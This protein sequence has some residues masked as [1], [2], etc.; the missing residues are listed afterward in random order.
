MTAFDMVDREA[1]TWGLD[2]ISHRNNTSKQLTRQYQY[3]YNPIAGDGATV[4]II[5][6]GIYTEHLVSI[7]PQRLKVEDPE[8]S[9]YISAGI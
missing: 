6:S 9:T 1:V 5:D 8:R 7:P 4:Y 2:R 3:I